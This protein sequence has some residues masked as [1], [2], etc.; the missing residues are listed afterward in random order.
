VERVHDLS[1]WKGLG[2]PVACT[3]GNFDGFHLGHQALL[4]RLLEWSR[5]LDLP[6]VVVTFDP[7]PAEVIHPKA[8]KQ[9]LIPMPDRLRILEAM[10]V[11]AT[12]V[13]KFDRTLSQVSAE[14]FFHRILVERVGVRHL[15]LGPDSHYGH[16]R[17][18]D[19]GLSVELGASLGMTMDRVEAVR[20]GGVAVSSTLIREL[21]AEGRVAEVPEYLGRHFRVRG[22][23]V[24]GRK[25]GAELGFPTANVDPAGTLLPRPGVYAGQLW[26]EGRCWAAAISVGTNPTFGNGPTTLEAHALDFTGDLYGRTVSVEFRQHLRDQQRFADQDQLIAQMKRDVAEVRRLAEATAE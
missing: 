8:V 26:V 1:K 15:V 22:E 4:E 21:V 10:G 9:R 11:A 12:V 25:R 5:L 19:F 13:L 24:K 20:V 16:D 23:V 14:D 2:R 17:R 3:L 7:H 6:A 18:G